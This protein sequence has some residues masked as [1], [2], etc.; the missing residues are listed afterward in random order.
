MTLD[1]VTLA[2]A[3]LALVACGA[4]LARVGPEAHL[5]RRYHAVCRRCDAAQREIE[6][7]RDLL[8]AH[9]WNDGRRLDWLETR[10]YGALGPAGSG[11]GWIVVDTRS[12]DVV[13]RGAT[14]REALDNAM[15]DGA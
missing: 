10:A 7:L 5:W 2:L 12:R 15:H 13:E 11:A 1:L 8:A 4:A 3:G 6:R 14:L 9:A